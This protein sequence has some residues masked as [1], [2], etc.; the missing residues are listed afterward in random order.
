LDETAPAKETPGTADVGM[1][2]RLVETATN[3]YA[4][5]S[6]PSAL[7]GVVT[8]APVTPEPFT[9][10]GDQRGVSGPP[11]RCATTT[12]TVTV[13]FIV[14]KT[15][16]LKRVAVLVDGRRRATLAGSRRSVTLK[17]RLGTQRVRVVLLA[18]DTKGRILT[19]TR[20]YGQCKQVP[21]GTLHFTV[22]KPKAKVTS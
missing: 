1:H 20:A 21:T 9:P 8:A 7:T 18:T 22:V 19:A 10:P 16:R 17:L 5:E 3:S 11:L 14:A 13:R 12:R 4:S 15:R 6:A 2:L